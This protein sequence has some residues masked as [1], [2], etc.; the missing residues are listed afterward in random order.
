MGRLGSFFDQTVQH[1]LA[2]IPTA[3]GLAA[4]FF[5]SRLS[6]KPLYSP[7][8]LV[9]LT[10]RLLS[11]TFANRPRTTQRPVSASP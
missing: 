5:K 10:I 4:I 8:A 6:A 2:E 1:L 9:F 11:Q 7:S 3:L